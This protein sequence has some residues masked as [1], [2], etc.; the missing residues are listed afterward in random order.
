MSRSTSPAR[1]HRHHRRTGA[2]PRG[3]VRFAVER[4]PINRFVRFLNS[5]LASPQSRKHGGEDSGLPRVCQAALGGCLEYSFRCAVS[6]LPPLLHVTREHMS[7]PCPLRTTPGAEP[8]EQNAPSGA[9]ENLFF[10]CLVT[11]WLFALLCMRSGWQAA[12]PAVRHR[13]L[14]IT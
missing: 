1:G 12:I 11:V 6:S 14:L 9:K 10:R 4:G 2:R 5:Y 13:R 8:A 7:L 3:S